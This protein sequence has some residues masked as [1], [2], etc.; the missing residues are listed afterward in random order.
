MAHAAPYNPAVHCVEASYTASHFH[1]RMSAFVHR[2]HNIPTIGLHCSEQ[3]IHISHFLDYSYFQCGHVNGLAFDHSS[4]AVPWW[5][6][7]GRLLIMQHRTR[8]KLPH[9]TLHCFVGASMCR[10][11]PVPPVDAIYR[12]HA[13]FF[14]KPLRRHHAIFVPHVFRTSS[15]HQQR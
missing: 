4:M 13:G 11:Q 2:M 12:L 6:S 15:A 1:I 3:S 9:S 10:W 7:D 14:P 8:R 5:M